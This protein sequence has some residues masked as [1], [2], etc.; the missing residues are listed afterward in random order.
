MLTAVGVLACAGCT[1]PARQWE[2]DTGE[3]R[4]IS[5]DTDLLQPSL[6]YF[7]PSVSACMV[8]RKLVVHF[9]FL[10]WWLLAAS[11]QLT[12]DSA[13][14]GSSHSDTSTALVDA[15]SIYFPYVPAGFS[16][17][18]NGQKLFFPNHDAHCST[19]GMSVFAQNFGRTPAGIALPKLSPCLRDAI[20]G[21]SY[22]AWNL[23][24]AGTLSASSVEEDRRKS[25]AGR[26]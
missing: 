13:L 7:R 19:M 17:E 24:T 25:D 15:C 11:L 18:M 6:G 20:W 2:I 4:R 21:Q 23:S 9:R 1:P 8:L 26:L 16:P 14:R 10:L 22:K 3:G 12:D 5:T